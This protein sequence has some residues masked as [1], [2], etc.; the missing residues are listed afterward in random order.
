MKKH[1]I[2]L[3]GATGYIGSKLLPELA[4]AGHEIK[5]IV[6]DPSRLNVSAPNITAF[7]GD[8]LE[9]ASLWRAFCGVDTAYFLVHFLHETRGFEEKEIQA[10]ENFA[11]M[12]RSAGVKRIIYLGALG[13]SEDNLSPHLRSRQDVGYILR[14]S[15]IP[16]LELRASIVLGNGSLSF[17]LIRDLTEHLPLMIMPR[18]VSTK[19]QPI[20]IDD[21][22]AYLFQSLEIPIWHSEIIEIGG[23]D[24][25]SYRDLMKEY[26]KLR[27]LHRLMLPV[28]VLT[29][30]LSSHWVAFFS[31]VNYTLARRLLAGVKNPTVIEN[32]RPRHRFRVKPQR[33]AEA[34]RRALE[35]SPSAQK[36]TN[37]SVLETFDEPMPRNARAS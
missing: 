26:A 32:N 14:H 25:L 30:W 33:A 16:T 21:L 12:A 1:K 20:G 34:M 9:R 11:H 35:E 7:K 5:C 3:T 28:P 4:A 29:P 18:W 23:E 10:A 2:L 13:N 17:E 8:L 36:E 15:G 31:S 27:G 37:V 19:A 24:C 22:L 6:R